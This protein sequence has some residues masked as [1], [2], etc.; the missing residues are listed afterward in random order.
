MKPEDG[1]ERALR[2][3]RREL[4]GA[5]DR[6]DQGFEPPPAPGAV[7]QRPG[8]R[9]D[10]DLDADPAARPPADRADVGDAVQALVAISA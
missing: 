4:A 8:D 9:G 7:P 2:H 6:L 3:P 10:V 1:H 5:P